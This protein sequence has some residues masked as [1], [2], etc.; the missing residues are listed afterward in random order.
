MGRKGK[1][2]PA[3]KFFP[4]SWVAESM[5]GAGATFRTVIVV[6]Y[7]T[8]P[9]SSSLTIKETEHT[10]SSPYVRADE[11]EATKG[12]APPAEFGGAG[13]TPS[14]ENAGTSGGPKSHAQANRKASLPRA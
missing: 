9:P 10:Q 14:L 12:Y 2:R 1:K 13:P 11:S 6:E 5:D 4:A 7:A 8:I 3:G